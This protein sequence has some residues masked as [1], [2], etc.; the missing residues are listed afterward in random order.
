M[1]SVIQQ[2]RKALRKVLGDRYTFQR[3]VSRLSLALLRWHTP[4]SFLEQTVAT[5]TV[6]SLRL[7]AVVYL[8]GDRVSMMYDF[9]VQE[10]PDTPEWIPYDYPEAP[11]VL[12][13]RGM[14]EVLDN[15]AKEHKLS[16]TGCNFPQ[17][18]PSGI[19]PK[20]T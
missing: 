10:R 6:G 9:L 13:E 14:F 16:Y 2:R 12:T 8:E 20:S 4:D 11:V 18:M 7:D 5:L 1:R 19:T 15:Y 17:T 3:K